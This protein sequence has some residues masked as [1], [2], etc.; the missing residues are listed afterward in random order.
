MM[1]GALVQEQQNL[2]HSLA[3]TVLRDSTHH[4]RLAVSKQQGQARVRMY[5]T[6][7]H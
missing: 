2:H 4:L 3:P 1:S 6:W 5:A 7:P